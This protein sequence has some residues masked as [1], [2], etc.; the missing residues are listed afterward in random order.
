MQSRAAAESN[1][2]RA[3]RTAIN[4]PQYSVSF[5]RSGILSSA[6]ETG[7]SAVASHT[8]AHHVLAYRPPPK[9][10]V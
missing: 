8:G 2:V 7:R 1:V 3:P 6:D 9:G 4:G 10:S 5:T